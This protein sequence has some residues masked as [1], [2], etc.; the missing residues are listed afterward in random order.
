[1]TG[2]RIGVAA[3]AA[4]MLGGCTTYDGYG[5][6]RYP[7]YDGGRY[8][9]AGLGGTG[10]DSLDPWLR[11]TPE[12][13]ALILYRF[14]R[15]YNGEIGRDRAI[16]AN[17]WF[18]FFADRNGDARVTDREIGAALDEVARQLRMR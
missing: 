3:L 6:D 12:G 5:H 11:D 8:G 10:V 1:M 4:A 9:R 2:K 7:G 13:R 17:R 14:D 15:N 16:E 18:R